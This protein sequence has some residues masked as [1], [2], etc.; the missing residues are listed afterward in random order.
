[1]IIKI[2]CDIPIYNRPSARENIAVP[3]ITGTKIYFK[4]AP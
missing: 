1:M 4:S 3:A 2:I